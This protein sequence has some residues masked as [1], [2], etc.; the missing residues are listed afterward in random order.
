MTEG[1]KDL[2]T[3]KKKQ[4]EEDTWL[5]TYAD[6]FTL[7]FAFFVLLVGS[8]TYDP[9]KYERVRESFLKTVH[10]DTELMQKRIDRKELEQEIEK[11]IKEKQLEK[12]VILDKN[13]KGLRMTFPS[14]G[15]FKSGDA[16][17][18]AESKKILT[19]IQEVFKKVKYKTFRIA[20]EGHTDDV[21]I[22]TEKF[23]S[24]WEL[25]SARAGSVANQLVQNGFKDE[26]LKVIGF[27]DTRPVEAIDEKMDEK[28]IKAVRSNN[29]RIELQLLYYK[30]D[31]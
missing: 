1:T 14:S 25:S 22:H 2:F 7:L 18:M 26:R 4:C 10:E 5:I 31:F 19:E 27:A 13:S 21:P 23:P 16:E 3:H 11:L 20:I 24:N 12:K 17:I 15:F 8:S 6:L 30:E 28:K 9:Q 29:R